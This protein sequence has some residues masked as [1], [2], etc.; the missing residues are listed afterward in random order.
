MLTT[1][2]RVYRI[3][4]DSKSVKAKQRKK[5]SISVQTITIR[6]ENMP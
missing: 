2:V 6:V 4:S 1:P 3:Y 5:K